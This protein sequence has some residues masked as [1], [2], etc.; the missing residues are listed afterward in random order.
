MTDALARPASSGDEQTLTRSGPKKRDVLEAWRRGADRYQGS[1]DGILDARD[2]ETGRLVVTSPDA[3]TNGT[4]SVTHDPYSSRIPQ[5]WMI[6]LQLEQQI[7]DLLPDVLREPSSGSEQA[8]TQA[9]KVEAWLR[10]AIEQQLPWRDSV[11]KAVRESE[12]AAYLLPSSAAWE[13]RPTWM[14]TQSESIKKQWWKDADGQPTGNKHGIDRGKSYKAFRESYERYLGHCL[15]ATYR[16]ISA[17]DCVPQ[18][19]R[20]WGRR[21][22]ELSSLIVRTLYDT[23]QL[24]AAGYR[25]DGMDRMLLPTGFASD[26]QQGQN[27][28]AYLYEWFYYAPD[29]GNPDD[30]IPMVS[31][32]V[33]GMDTWNPSMRSASDD[34]RAEAVV[35]LRERYGLRRHLM[36]YY[37][38]F[39]RAGEDDP[40]RKAIPMMSIW[41]DT[42]IGIETLVMATKKHANETAFRGYQFVPNP[43][44][45]V[46]AY[47]YGTDGARTMRA[48][49]LPGSGEVVSVPGEFKPVAPAQLSPVVNYLIEAERAQLQLTA[50]DQSQFG[51]GGASS[52]HELSV[53]HA[54]FQSANS[55]I[56]EGLRQQV[57][58]L[59]EWNLE[60]AD[61]L[62]ET[63]NLDAIPITSNQP[64]GAD[65][66]SSNRPVK[67]QLELT[68]GLIG[69][70]YEITAFYPAVGNLAE[71]AEENNL[72]KDGMSTFERVA[73]KMGV[74]DPY[75]LRVEIERD[76]Y[77]DSPEGMA[78]K[79]IWL[80][81]YRGDEE[82]AQK[83]IQQGAL[84]PDGQTPMD[85]I[86]PE[87]M[88]AAQA[89]VGGGGA[90]PGGMPQGAV[91]AAPMGPGG[92]STGES[93]AGGIIAGEM[94]SASTMAD[95]VATSGIPQVPQP[96]MAGGV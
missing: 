56:K 52:G 12:W 26:N 90:P 15:P 32:S 89:A 11:G 67:R 4:G 37:W 81:R 87:A 31:Y 82:T 44:I 27:G 93:A 21:R 71:V 63:F 49:P 17:L 30:Q 85:A 34:D 2:L 73:E 18:F 91:Q 69:E 59:G 83:L 8:D 7:G 1:R 35:N 74:N 25:W 65:A 86:S 92:P 13:K 88:A 72:R 84:N 53:S 57:E 45:P 78:L 51:G 58:D 3:Q 50:P 6:P 33:A 40:A 70:N 19:T 39:H 10:G 55:H 42:I 20:G 22:W 14:D 75:T 36:G 60:L 46:E 76:K 47:T 9:Q 29:P 95:A 43:D 68:R 38:G 24:L 48:F 66:G 62:M 41:E 79:A 77:L 94:G 96:R 54:L 5:R 64:A 16:L 23:E 80:A 61:C 28:L